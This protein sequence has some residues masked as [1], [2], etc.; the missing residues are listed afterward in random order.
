MVGSSLK[1]AM[2]SEKAEMVPFSAAPRLSSGIMLRRR[3]SM[4]AKRDLCGE[5]CAEVVVPRKRDFRQSF[6]NR[7]LAG[8]LIL[9][10]DDLGE[11]QNCLEPTFTDLS[12]GVEDQP[13]LI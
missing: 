4:A 11:R 6:Q 7:T 13:L 2:V 3:E 12:D 10:D 9:T 8:G 5:T 1:S